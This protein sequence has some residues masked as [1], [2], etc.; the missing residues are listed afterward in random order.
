M[1]TFIFVILFATTVFAS[2]EADHTHSHGEIEHLYP[3]I[4]IFVLLAVVGI[5]IGLRKKN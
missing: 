3:V 5:V 2:G 4:G 1:T